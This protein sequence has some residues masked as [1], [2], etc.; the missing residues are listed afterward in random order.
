MSLSSPVF[1]FLPPT[2]EPASAQPAANA[3]DPA[4]RCFCLQ[5][6]CL[7]TCP[8]PTPGGRLSQTP[9]TSQE[10]SLLA[11]NNGNVQKCVISFAR[12]KTSQVGCHMSLM[13]ESQP[14]TSAPNLGIFK[15]KPG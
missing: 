2:Q 3:Y 15:E 14:G 13:Q 8:C 1:G 10:C 6:G 4:C 7:L 11:L 9:C 5:R 12:F